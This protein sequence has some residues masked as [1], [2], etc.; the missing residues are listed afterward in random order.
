[1]ACLTLALL[2]ITRKSGALSADAI[3][4]RG[5]AACLL[6]AVTNFVLH[7][8]PRQLFSRRSFHLLLLVLDLILVSV[9]VYLATGADASEIG[10]FVVLMLCVLSGAITG[11]AR[12]SFLISIF[13]GGIY[14]LQLRVWRPDFAQLLDPS[15][16]LRVPL[17]LIFSLIAALLS[18]GAE[19][20]DRRR[21]E[22]ILAFTRQLRITM[23]TEEINAKLVEVLTSRAGYR[24]AALY[25]LD[26]D[27][28]TYQRIGGT[29]F[30]STIDLRAMP[31][32][33]AERLRSGSAVHPEHLGSASAFTRSLGISVGSSFLVPAQSSERS[34]GLLIAEHRRT[35]LHF[36]PHV[37]FLAQLVEHA[38]YAITNSRMVQ[39]AQESTIGL[40]GLL[41]MS[42]AARSTLKARDILM[43]LEEFCIRLV[44]VASCR[45][46]VARAAFGMDSSETETG[47]DAGAEGGAF[48]PAGDRVLFG[49]AAI[50]TAEAAIAKVWETGTE[51]LLNSAEAVE[52]LEAGVET[53]NLMAMPLRTPTE[54]L[55]VLVAL[56]K[57][58]SFTQ[59]DHSILEGLAS[60]ATI[61]LVNARLVEGLEARTV[62]ITGL[63]ETLGAE[64]HK[65]EHVLSNM[66]EG[67]VLLDQEG[68]VALMNHAGRRLLAPQGHCPL[69][70]EANRFSDPLGLLPRLATILAGHS[71]IHETLPSGEHYYELSA[72]NLKGAEGA[73]AVLRDITELVRIDA[74]RTDF[75]SHVS[76]ELR[77]PLAAIIGSI[78]LILEGRAGETT[79]V[80]QRLLNIVERESSLLMQLIND[81][82][83][84]AKLEAGT[85][86]LEKTDVDLAAVIAE[87]AESMQSLAQSKSIDLA[88]ECEE[89]IAPVPCDPSL[90]RQLLHNLIGNAIKFTPD[91]GSVRVVASGDFT[92]AEVQVIDTGI[93][94]PRDKWEAVFNKFEQLGSHNGPVKGTGLGLAI[95][96]QIVDRHGGR[97]WVQ[98]EEGLGST[99]HFTLPC[100]DPIVEVRTETIDEDL[101][102]ASPTS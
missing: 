74:M 44:G 54:M 91:R 59:R 38:A 25:L 70:A 20:A 61:A 10:F 86:T 35:I 51:L 57:P 94:I 62:R 39:S 7:R 89:L 65:L 99:F 49:G 17:L 67:V 26:P 73:I 5:L 63:V 80:Q 100:C 60:Q 77:T 13:A 101:R 23:S 9:V 24:R 50:P 52:G 88:C 92:I 31:P 15:T 83:D 46:S 36:D 1:M 2:L 3:D 84:L 98:S 21:A 78:R 82:L 8:S 16:L 45:I 19:R 90:I 79:E 43:L 32:R 87:A 96:R 93:G 40:H 69:P 76:H 14:L 12:A 95:C 75:V 68:R 30:P 6:I 18:R 47:G 64:K 71:A 85:A 66:E 48:P 11:D 55:G 22:A 42:E 41:K 56:D 37:S 34:V 81:L 4:P 28:V 29:P 102:C 97:I 72:A 58:G 33:I 53:S 27:Q